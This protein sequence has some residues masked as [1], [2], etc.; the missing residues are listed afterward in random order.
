MTNAP[1]LVDLLQHYLASDHL[2]FSHWFELI[3]YFIGR[4]S[5]ASF[6]RREEISLA[7]RCASKRRKTGRGKENHHL[8]QHT[9]CQSTSTNDHRVTYSARGRRLLFAAGVKHTRETVRVRWFFSIGS[10]DLLEVCPNR[11]RT[12]NPTELVR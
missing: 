6:S 9:S 12:S 2:F 5:L 1:N 7:S 4:F 10:C 8:L 11:L 3:F